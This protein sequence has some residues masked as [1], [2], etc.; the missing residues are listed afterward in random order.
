M[1]A[2]GASGNGAGFSGLPFYPCHC[3]GLLP[4]VAGS[5][6]NMAANP[7]PLQA[8]YP[9]IPVL[10]TYLQ[11]MRWPAF[12]ALFFSIRRYWL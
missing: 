1:V 10:Q 5:L 8:F 2:P 6:P 9:P 7:G 11:A 3:P 4:F 12:W